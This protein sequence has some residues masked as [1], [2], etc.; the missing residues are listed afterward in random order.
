[1]T[2]EV[3]NLRRARKN[4]ARADA[5]TT[6]AANRAAHRRTQAEKQADAAD[7]ARRDQILDGA[8]RDR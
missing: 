6:A 8:R 2:A 5:A 1:V 7:T 3:V 4:R